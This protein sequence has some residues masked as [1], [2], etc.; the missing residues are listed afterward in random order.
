MIVIN[1]DL[2]LN[3]LIF[4]EVLESATL[5]LHSDF[6]NE[7]FEIDLGINYSMYNRFSHFELTDY[8]GLVNGNYIYTLVSESV[9]IG[10]GLCK[11]IQSG[12]TSITPVLSF[13]PLHDD[14]KVFK[15]NG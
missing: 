12:T 6:T 1:K 11:I 7:D 13:N 14:L 4:S 5:L 15:L 10:T 3:N 8:T 2:E 9:V